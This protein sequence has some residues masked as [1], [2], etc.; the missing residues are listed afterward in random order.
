MRKYF[1]KIFARYGNV[2]VDAVTANVLMPPVS[3]GG[4]LFWQ[5]AVWPLS[6][7]IHTKFKFSVHCLREILEF[8]RLFVS[9][10]YLCQIKMWPFKKWKCGLAPLR[11]SFSKVWLCIEFKWSPDI[12][13]VLSYISRPLAT[14]SQEY[15]WFQS[16]RFLKLLLE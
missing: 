9:P 8:W 3:L 12:M 2:I 14:D 13:S 1:I 11:S 6:I 4:N 10:G 15:K 5:P 7:S 16:N